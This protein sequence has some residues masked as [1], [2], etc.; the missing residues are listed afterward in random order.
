MER[1]LSDIEFGG[2]LIVASATLLWGIASIVS[3]VAL[4]WKQRKEW[5]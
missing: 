1:I 2:F 3:G 4:I 5:L